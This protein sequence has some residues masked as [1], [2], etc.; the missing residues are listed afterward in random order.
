MF[1]SDSVKTSC[2]CYSSTDKTMLLIKDKVNPLDL[3]AEGDR[4]ECFE[5]A[6]HNFIF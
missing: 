2:G 6:M 4:R 3:D 5:A 1:N